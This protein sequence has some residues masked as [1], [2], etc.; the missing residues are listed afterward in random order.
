[1]ILHLH[2]NIGF[3]SKTCRIPIQY[4]ILVIALHSL[5]HTETKTLHDSSR[6]KTGRFGM[7]L[8]CAVSI[9]SDFT[10]KT[11]SKLLDRII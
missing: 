8:V 3:H 11:M 7:K 5:F 2:Q 9:Q 10:V 4:F 6:Q 1:M